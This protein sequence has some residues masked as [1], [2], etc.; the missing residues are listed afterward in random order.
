MR[1]S[2]M[3]LASVPVREANRALEDQQYGKTLAGAAPRKPGKLRGM[4][5]ARFFPIPAPSLARDGWRTAGMVFIGFGLVLVAAAADLY[6]AGAY[7]LGLL[8][9]VPIAFASWT[10]GR[11]AGLTVLALALACWYSV[12][13]DLLETGLAAGLFSRGGTAVPRPAG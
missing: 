9:L 5:A 10:S 12:R 8:Y 1:S 4:R 13:G 3:R 7:R 11:L 6:S 2:P